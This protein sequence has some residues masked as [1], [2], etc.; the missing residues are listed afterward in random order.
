MTEL[1]ALVRPVQALAV[2][3]ALLLAP[4]PMPA[5]AQDRSAP[6]GEAAGPGGEGGPGPADR[7]GP[8]GP[9]SPGGGGS[10][11]DGAGDPGNGAQED[12]GEA[13][14][15]APEAKPDPNAPAVTGL[16]N[17]LDG[18]TGAAA[19][20]GQ[21]AGAQPGS[22]S[23][24]RPA[25]PATAVPSPGFNST[26]LPYAPSRALGPGDIEE[27]QKGAVYLVARL[28]EGGAQITDGLV[29]RVYSETPRDNGELELIATAMGGDA[30]FRLDPGAYLIHTSYG[31]AGVTNRLVVGRGVYSKTVVLNAGG[32]RLEAGL[33][34][35]DPLPAED[36]RFD[37]YGMDY[38]T[39]G[40]RNLIVG[41]VKPDAIVRLNSGTYHVA[42]RYG[43]V[44]A[45]V[46]ADLSV[47][48]GKLTS[49]TLFHEAAE[50]T[51][52]LVN[53][54]GGEAIANT[55]W[56]VLTPGGDI[57]V[58]ETGAFPAFVLAAGEYEVI[59]RNNGTNYSRNFTVVSGEDREVE[60]LARSVSTSN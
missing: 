36:I 29:W 30:E 34:A 35:D 12:T 38:N 2:V 8:D 55:G 49:A 37:I 3:L 18:P 27:T 15:P 43:E 41:G 9:G 1:K 16:P 39:Q 6:A 60:V 4:A 53:E 59:A 5:G 45:V 25:A 58:E 23:G 56:T 13:L 21:T 14:P 32:I 11:S 51:L 26:L 40:E 44:N 17:P 28:T 33:S 46:R 57:V 10:G 54:A 42:S 22:Q 47:D 19:G 52:K 31:F 24:S 7:P 20:A 48:A 50:I